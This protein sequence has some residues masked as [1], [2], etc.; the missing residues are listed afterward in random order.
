MRLTFFLRR[1][2][3]GLYHDHTQ[4]W[5]NLCDQRTHQSAHK[6]DMQFVIFRLLF[7]QGKGPISS[8]FLHF[9][10]WPRVLPKIDVRST[11]CVVLFCAWVFVYPYNKFVVEFLV[12]VSICTCLTP[13]AAAP[14]VSIQNMHICSAQ[15]A[16]FPLLSSHACTT[17]RD[18]ASPIASLSDLP[19]GVGQGEVQE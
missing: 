2:A 8:P 10:T 6:R 5:W 1:L 16:H 7:N 13:V 4:I 18:Q 17:T 12:R 9:I 11:E 15:G 3:L 14:R 19:T